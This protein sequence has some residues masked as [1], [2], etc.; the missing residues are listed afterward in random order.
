MIPTG[1]S[2]HRAGS[3]KEAVNLLAKHGDD[4]KILAG[5]HSLIPALK[6]RLNEVGML[7][8]IAKIPELKSISTAAGHLVIGGCCTH[9]E[10]AYSRVV[11]EQIPMVAEAAE[12]IGDVQVRNRGTIGGSLAHADPAADWPAVMLAADAL[13]EVQG[14]KGSREIKAAD[15]FSGFYETAL[16]DHEVITAIRMPL[17]TTG[18][19]T[20]YQKFMQPAS[21]FALVGCAAVIKNDGGNASEVKVAFTGVSEAPFRDSGVENALKGKTLSV[22]NIAAAAEHAAA[23]VSIMSDHFASEEYRKHLAK[24]YARRALAAA[25]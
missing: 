12:L 25:S 14:P 3:V 17:L 1:F 20:S 8:D 13:I 6:L 4:A 9:S 16:S 5:G 22:D 2:Y 7:I 23:D 11:K 24:V 19:K 10:I 21:R 18:T 15:F